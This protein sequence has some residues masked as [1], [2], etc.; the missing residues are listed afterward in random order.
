MQIRWA[1]CVACLVASFGLA[2]FAGPPLR[3]RET[4]IV[5]G[6]WRFRPDPLN[7]DAPAGWTTR[8]PESTTEFTV[9]GVWAA[10]GAPQTVSWY[11]REFDAPAAWKEKGRHVRLRFGALAVGSRVWVNGE[12]AGESRLAGLPIDLDVSA[13]IRSGERNLIAVR[14]PLRGAAAARSEGDNRGIWQSAS[15]IVADEAHITNLAV[16]AKQNGWVTVQVS[17]RNASDKTGAA[18]LR[19]ELFRADDPKKRV[20]AA[21][22]NVTVTPGE[23]RADIAIKVNRPEPWS[24]GKP[25]LYV[26]RVA[27]MQ[28]RDIL[29]N[30]ESTFGFRDVGFADGRLTIN[31]APLAIQGRLYR[32]VRAGVP[33]SPDAATREVADAGKAGIN[34]LWVAGGPAH[35]W[36]LDAADKAGILVVESAD[37]RSSAVALVRRDRSHPSVVLWDFRGSAEVPADLDTTR[38]M[39]FGSSPALAE[40]VTAS[41]RIGERIQPQG[42]AIPPLSGE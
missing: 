35:P 7:R 26:A 31:N 2:G 20:A 18:E 8:I 11:W 32:S 13:S 15:L 37:S 1:L 25:S 29:D 24:P 19:A 3:G 28:D 12:V 39:I 16:N 21:T 41:L 42:F 33:A 36:L 40:G 38:P 22:Q 4:V 34:L 30:D 10:N 23:N 5:D 14:E 6:A 9:P 27:F 17:L